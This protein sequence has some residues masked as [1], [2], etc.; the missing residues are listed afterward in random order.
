MVKLFQVF[1][2]WVGLSLQV[3]C[4]GADSVEGSQQKTKSVTDVDYS[5]RSSFDIR[6]EGVVNVN[7]RYSTQEFST[8]TL[9][10]DEVNTIKSKRYDVKQVD[11]ENIN[12]GQNEYFS[13]QSAERNKSFQTKGFETS[14]YKSFQEAQFDRGG[15]RASYEGQVSSHQ[16]KI[17]SRDSD[18]KEFSQRSAYTQEEVRKLLNRE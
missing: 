15:K 13:G 10:F 18:N 8:K 7:Q 16:S 17:T 1:M 4:T 12:F 6:R 5:K 3:S 14:E 9:S 11:V 2:I